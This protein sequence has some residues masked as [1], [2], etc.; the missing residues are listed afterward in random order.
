MQRNP[1]P[2]QSH[3][4]TGEKGLSGS[5]SAPAPQMNGLVRKRTVFHVA[6]YDPAPPAAVRA[7]LARELR[8]FEETWAVRA[9]VSDATPADEAAWHIVATGPNWRVDTDF[10][11][12]RWDDLIA[13]AGRRPMW[14]RIPLGLLA[15]LDF[16][17]HALGRYWR[18]NWRYA[19]FFLFPFL[20]FLALAGLAAC[21]GW[22]T[23]QV[24]GS[25]LLGM[26]AG[27]AVLAILLHW[28]G[29]RLYLSLLFDDWIFS[30][31]YLRQGDPQLEARLDQ[32]AN[33]IVAVAQ[34]SEVDEIVIVG[35]SL[36]AALAIDLLDRA[37]RLDSK[38]GRARPR[39]ALVTIGSSILKIALHA[40]AKRFRAA[41]ERI[42][43]A[44]NIFW[45]DYQAIADV[46][47]FYKS[48]PLAA[49]GLTPGGGPLVRMVRFRHMLDPA[50]YARMRYHPYR[51][52]CQFVSGNN[53]R[54]AYDYFMLLCGPLA[55]ERQARLPEGAVSAIGTDGA[56]L[57]ELAMK[58]GAGEQQSSPARP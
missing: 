2:E 7:R 10:R 1:Q 48:D 29:R 38:L 34:K 4:V 11:L 45:G 37:L 24:S 27:A 12:V 6:G 30:R 15:F 50:V 35:H 44:A 20:L 58:D 5:A 13:A 21:A 57:D 54:A 51:L 42:A 26:I 46:M 41:V 52:H 31:G 33:D 8:R 22:L 43:S 3:A 18:A 40:R 9:A 39:V 14:G 49:L 16:A 32:I 17:V 53:R 28:P 55:V 19:L 56:L 36:G 47:N 23:A 25:T